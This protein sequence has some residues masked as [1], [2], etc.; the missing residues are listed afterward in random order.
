[1]V[2]KST[3]DGNKWYAQIPPTQEALAL[4]SDAPHTEVMGLKECLFTCPGEPPSNDYS[5]RTWT[6]GYITTGATA[7]YICTSK[8][9][10]EFNLTGFI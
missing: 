4:D 1:M 10:P 3:S 2:C 8:L 9:Q 7:E 5:N 6:E